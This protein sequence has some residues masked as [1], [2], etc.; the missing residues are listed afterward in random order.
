MILTEEQIEHFFREGY[1]LAPGLVSPQDAE[2][3]LAA[4]RDRVGESER[5]QATIFN[6]DAPETDPEI[7]RL[8]AHPRVVEAARQCLGSPPRVWYG[9]LAVVRAH[10]GDGLPWHQDNQYT[11]LLGG[12]MNIFIALTPVREENGGLWI[13]PRSHWLGTQPSRRNADTAPGH[14]EALVTPEG[15][16]ALPPMAPGDACLFDRCTYHRSGKNATGE[17]RFAYA[18]QYQAEHTRPALTGKRDP[19]RLLATDLRRLQDETPAV[20]T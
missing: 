11:H 4:G 8:L 14:R 13:A 15:G 1:V 2:A 6:H 7:H 17:H 5:W 16:F 20:K 12:A 3:V 19:K 10:G 18:A 9:M